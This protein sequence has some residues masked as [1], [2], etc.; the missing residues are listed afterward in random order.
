MRSLLNSLPALLALG[1]LGACSK[2]ALNPPSLAPRAAEKIDPRIPVEH[3]IVK[4]G[5]NLTLAAKLAA[6]LNEA[7]SG[8]TA[9]RAALGPAQKAVSAAGTA[10][11]ESWITAQQQLSALESARAPTTRAAAAIDAL[12]GDAVKADNGIDTDE[13]SAIQRASQYADAMAARQAGEIAAMA[14]RLGS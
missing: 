7:E 6:L 5:A 11:S 4:R 8:D 10:R 9:F 13:L 3:P 12:A 14:A 1:L 2:S